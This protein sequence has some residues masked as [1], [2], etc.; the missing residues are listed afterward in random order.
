MVAAETF[1]ILIGK[2]D[3]AVSVVEAKKADL[4]AAEAARDKAKTEYEVSVDDAK[5]IRLRVDERM[6][7]ILPASVT[8]GRIR[9]A[10]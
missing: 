6:N 8:S 3:K 5:E 10:A 1:L 7:A 4:V 9:G 2:L